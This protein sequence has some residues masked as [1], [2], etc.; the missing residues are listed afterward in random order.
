MGQL[1][2]HAGWMIAIFIEIQRQEKILPPMHLCSGKM[3][4]KKKKIH[5][6]SHVGPLEC[7]HTTGTQVIV[8]SLK[9]R[10]QNGSKLEN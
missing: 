4:K 1:G 2:P 10:Q 5:I 3:W 6:I 8:Q 9:T 7:S